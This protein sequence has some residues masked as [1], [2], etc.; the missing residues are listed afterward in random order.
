MW[1]SAPARSKTA[2]VERD[3]AGGRCLNYACIL[4]GGPPHGRGLRPMEEDL[5]G[6]K[7]SG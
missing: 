7:A 5:T 3:K 2:V 4:P 1:A 6:V